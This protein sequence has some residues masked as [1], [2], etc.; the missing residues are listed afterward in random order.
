MNQ[1][2]RKNDIID[3]TDCL[4]AVTVFKSMKNWLFVSALLSLLFLQLVF[5]ANHLG[6][7]DKSQC[8]CVPVRGCGADCK[9]LLDVQSSAAGTY[10][11]L[12]I[13][14]AMALADAPGSTE[15]VKAEEAVAEV[16]EIPAGETEKVDQTTEEIAE[17]AKK[18]VDALLAPLEETRPEPIVEEPSTSVSQ[19]CWKSMKPRWSLGK[20]DQYLPTCQQTTWAIRIANFLLLVSLGL[21]C[22]SLLMSIKISLAGRL[23][24][25]NH[26]S[27]AFFR[28]LFALVFAIP[29][30]VLLP[31]ILLG[32][33]YRPSELLCGPACPSA[34]TDIVWIVLFY[35]R[36][37]GMWLLV[38][39]FL[40]AA[41]SRS[42]KWARATLRRLG[43]LH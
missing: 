31:G 43:I 39:L 11:D 29:W 23:G 26:I 21:Y 42:C 9:C 7:I 24:G 3:T 10:P 38:F 35:L 15:P 20:F 14:T 32:A 37:C 33:V 25:L 36:F 13:C 19:P 40:C 6:Y 16:D 22:L 18:E 2:E 34:Q 8:T 30:Q 1:I 5:W 28:S 27:R 12:M 17:Q 41:Q 4:E